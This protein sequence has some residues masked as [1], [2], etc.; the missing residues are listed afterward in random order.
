MDTDIFQLTTIVLSGVAAVGFL[1]AIR[2]RARRRASELEGAATALA[3]HF[4][5][6]EAVAEDPAI[7]VEALEL[8]SFLSD[9]ISRQDFCDGLTDHL[10]EPKSNGGRD[11]LPT[12]FDQIEEL[13][14]TRPDLAANFY[15]AMATGMTAAILRW[16][17]NAKKLAEF[18]AIMSQGE[19]KE[20][21]LAERLVQI[22]RSH[23]GDG[24]SSPT[25]IPVAA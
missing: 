5:A 19:R 9:G 14:R 22:R 21:A 16:P 12:W 13:R 24:P 25:G 10:V 6:L 2:T 1:R 18:A 11:R 4:D 20:A 15:K 17:D 23:N 7:P 8:L 3:A